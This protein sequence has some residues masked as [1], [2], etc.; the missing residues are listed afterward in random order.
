M[1]GWFFGVDIII[2]SQISIPAGEEKCI[3]NLVLAITHSFSES[4]RVCGLT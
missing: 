2:I 3:I 4:V 1:V